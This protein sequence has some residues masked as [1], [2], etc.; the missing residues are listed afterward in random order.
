MQGHRSINMT[1]LARA[2]LVVLMA[3]SVCACGI[4]APRSSEGYANLDSLGVFD[5]DRTMALSIGRLPIRIALWA[6][7]EDGDEPEVAAMLRSL[8]GVRIRIYE[9]DGNP[10]R[11]AARIQRM[12]AHLRKDRWQPVMLVQDDGEE[13]HMLVRQRGDRILGLTLITSDGSSEA[14]VINVMGDIRPE[15]FGDVMVALDVDAPDVE[16]AIEPQPGT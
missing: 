5:T 13:T 2:G 10:A 7:E 6:L 12:S 9:I 14:V 11:V 15:Q 1:G 3:A 16:I 8:D 4:T